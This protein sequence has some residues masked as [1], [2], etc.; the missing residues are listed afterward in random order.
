MPA[1]FGEIADFHRDESARFQALAQAARDRGSLGEAEYLTGLATRHSEAAQEQ[2][3]EMVRVPDSSVAE[4]GL[5]HGSPQLRSTSF[6]AAC[7]LVLLRGA[8]RLLTAIGPP[9]PK[10][11]SPVHGYSNR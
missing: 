7:R 2:K 11:P 9:A 5:Q 6:L 4:S 8:E 1:D 10:R 3:N